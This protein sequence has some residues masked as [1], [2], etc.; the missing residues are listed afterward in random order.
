MWNRIKSLVIKELIA[1]WQDKKSRMLLLIPP[2]MML[3]LFSY[4]ATLEVKNVTIGILN[5]DR[6]S[7]SR[8]LLRRIQGSRTF[9][10]LLFTRNLTE[11]KDAVD[12]EKALIALYIQA[13]FT[14][15][16]L[17][18]ETA[19]V[20]VIIDGRHLNSGQIVQGYITQ[21]IRQFNLTLVQDK[22]VY[23]SPKSTVI[24]RR[25]FNPNLDYMWFTVPGLVAILTLT[26]TINVT[27]L[28]VARER[29]L[30]TFDQLLVSPLKPIEILIGKTVPAIIIGLSEGT[31]MTLAGILIFHIPFTG[32]L[33][34]LYVSML[35]FLLSVT[36]IGLFISSLA[37]TQQQ[38]VLGSF[39]FTNP[40]ITLSGYASPIENMPD[41][42]QTITI[43]NPLRY[44]LVILKGSFLKSLPP[45][46]I[47]ANLWPMVLIALFT[48]T[49][50][51][52]FF[53]RRLE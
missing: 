51:S 36:G 44:F 30:G 23:Q 27:A 50:A 38:A 47:L 14:E 18:Q 52:W 53:K 49:G 32:S 35:V 7:L 28:S 12:S 46:I 29:E 10:H 13:D 2:M 24:P 40:S 1:I 4:A 15:K 41:W 16:I 19:D 3:F 33:F 20:Q 37:K 8:E 43:I 21:I 34:W 48:L 25:W 39:L 22:S 26:V 9:T 17:A 11:L 42:L 45:D 5:R 31:L 6:G